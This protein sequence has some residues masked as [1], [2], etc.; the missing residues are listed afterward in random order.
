MAVTVL[1]ALPGLPPGLRPQALDLLTQRP[2]WALALLDAIAAE[3]VKKSFMTF[4]WDKPDGSPT[5]LKMEFSSSNEGQ[6]I[7]ITYQ[8]HW[9]VIRKIDSAN[10]VTYV[11]K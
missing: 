1:E 5:S 4:K 10:N 2:E 8:E 6:F 9:D 3:K 7:P 11:C